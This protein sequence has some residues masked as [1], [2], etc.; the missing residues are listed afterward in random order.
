[1]VNSP[2]QH[3]WDC[4]C[5][6]GLLG[7]SLLTRQAAPNI[8]F[9][10]IVAELI[11]ELEHKLKQ[12]YSDSPVAW[13][14]LCLD[15]TQIP[16]SQYEG[17][18]LVII[19]GVGGDLMT[20]LV[21]G[22]VSNNPNT[23]ID[24]LLCPVHHQFTLRKKLIELDFSLKAELL[25]EENKRFYEI[26]SVSSTTKNKKVSLVGDKIWQAD[27]LKQAAIIKRYFDKTL[28]HY[29]R[30]QSGKTSNVQNIIDAYQEKSD[31]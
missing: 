19:A 24:F 14:T 5:D 21:E 15:V 9:V 13:S 26:I 23:D 6:H 22:I 7:A 31:K 11:N 17:K 4:C 8:Y 30:I 12:F 29:Q 20:E 28:S 3:I 1:M 10:D 27:S 16:L 18:Q 25:I 2:Y